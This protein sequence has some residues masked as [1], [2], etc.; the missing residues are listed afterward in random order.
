[1]DELVMRAMRTRSSAG[2]LST[3]QPNSAGK[4]EARR[5]HRAIPRSQSKE[6]WIV[7][8][9]DRHARMILPISRRCASIGL[10]VAKQNIH[11][12]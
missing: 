5:A 9:N 12:G 6:S 8:P 7:R 2:A 4:P 11:Y 1:M 3:A 10:P